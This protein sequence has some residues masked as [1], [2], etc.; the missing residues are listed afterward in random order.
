MTIIR[1]STASGVVG[2]ASGLMGEYGEMD[3]VSSE[4]VENGDETLI[5]FKD[6]LVSSHYKI[7]GKRS[8]PFSW[9]IDFKI[10][11]GDLGPTGFSEL[12]DAYPD[13][14]PGKDSTET[15]NGEPDPNKWDDWSDQEQI[16]T[17][18]GLR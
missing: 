17:L 6:F 12:T 18:S 11:N 5:G 10:M 4:Y 14:I 13:N 15:N 3:P 7:G 1:K 2:A 9:D 16:D 8:C